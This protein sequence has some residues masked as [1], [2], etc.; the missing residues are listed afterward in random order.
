M[1][2]GNFMRVRGLSFGLVNGLELYKKQIKREG[3]GAMSERQEVRTHLQ[4][5]E[6]QFSYMRCMGSTGVLRLCTRTG[7]EIVGPFTG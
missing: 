4:L 2:L 3:G 6:W 7:S 5:H 1:I